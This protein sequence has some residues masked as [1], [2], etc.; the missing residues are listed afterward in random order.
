MENDWHAVGGH[1]NVELDGV[2]SKSL[3]SEECS[4][5]VLGELGRCSAMSMDVRM[6]VDSGLRRHVSRLAPLI[7]T[8]PKQ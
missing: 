3:G 2:S 1:V 4:H 5:G 8:V 7:W 6:E